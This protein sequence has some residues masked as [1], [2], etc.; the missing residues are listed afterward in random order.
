M[1][2]AVSSGPQRCIFLRASWL[3]LRMA[4][5]RLAV[6]ATTPWRGT[7]VNYGLD[8]LLKKPRPTWY[9]ITF[10]AFDKAGEDDQA[11]TGVRNPAR[12][13]LTDQFPGQ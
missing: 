1:R 9:W 12:A 7:L 8:G 2:H 13:G 5:V 11:G 10:W 3:A 4:R 6:S